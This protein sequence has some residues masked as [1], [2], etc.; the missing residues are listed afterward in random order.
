ML[1]DSVS[2]Y[3][4]VRLCVETLPRLSNSIAYLAFIN[5]DVLFVKAQSLAAAV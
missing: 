5:R 1:G 4:Q 3:S 2:R